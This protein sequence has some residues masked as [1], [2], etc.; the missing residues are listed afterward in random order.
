MIADHVRQV[1]SQQASARSLRCPRSVVLSQPASIAIGLLGDVMLGRGVAETRRL[2]PR[3]VWAPSFASWLRRWTS[4]SATSSAAS[5][6]AG[7]QPPRLLTSR[8]SSRSAD[9]RR[10]IARNQRRRCQPGHPTTCSTSALMHCATH[11]EARAGELANVPRR[12]LWPTN[13]QRCCKLAP[14]SRSHV[15][16]TGRRRAGG[17]RAAPMGLLMTAGSALRQHA[18]GVVCVRSSPCSTGFPPAL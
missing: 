7:A 12:V 3:E 9:G 17:R 5:R 6:L 8:S 4:S 13:R 1:A 10:C 11:T 2:Q 16:R 15:R 14:R 18:R